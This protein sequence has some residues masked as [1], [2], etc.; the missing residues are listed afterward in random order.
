MSLSP[1]SDTPVCP[2]CKHVDVSWKYLDQY[3]YRT[4][5]DCGRRETREHHCMRCY[6]CGYAWDMMVEQ[7]DKNEDAE[8]EHPCGPMAQVAFTKENG[9][10]V[11]HDTRA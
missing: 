4:R 1:F 10:E 8:V 3:D 9:Q 6:R 2:K 11:K 5:F 7:S